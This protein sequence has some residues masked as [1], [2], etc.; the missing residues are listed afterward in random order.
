MNVSIIE[1]LRQLPQL[2]LGTRT[3]NG[4]CGAPVSDPLQRLVWFLGVCT[5]RICRLTQVI[6][7]SVFQI[8][9]KC[10]GSAQ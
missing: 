9:I 4:V 5:L 10:L 6:L 7:P 1:F 2:I 3:R 8:L